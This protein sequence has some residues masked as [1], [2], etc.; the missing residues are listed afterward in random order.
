MRIQIWICL[1]P[2]SQAATPTGYNAIF[3]H[4]GGLSPAEFQ[5]GLRRGVEAGV[6]EHIW[7]S[8][9]HT[10]GLG[11]LLRNT[12]KAERLLL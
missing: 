2:E 9:S 3:C 6:C 10:S 7:V 11:F 8:G 12:E 4:P 1:T 5:V